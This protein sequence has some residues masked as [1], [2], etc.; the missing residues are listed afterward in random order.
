M[1]AAARLIV[2]R[3]PDEGREFDVSS[4]LAHIGRDGS[5]QI[6]LTDPGLAR[7]QASIVCRGG[8]YALFT[9]LDGGVE[10]DGAQVPAERWVWLPAAADIRFGLETVLHFETSTPQNGHAPADSGLMVSNDAPTDESAAVTPSQKKDG[11]SSTARRRRKKGEP[12]KSAARLTLDAAGEPRVQLGADGRLPELNLSE[13]GGPV[14]ESSGKSS[15]QPWLVIVAVL[16]STAMSALLLLWTPESGGSSTAAHA[17]A[18]FQL[19][20]FYGKEGSDLEPYQQLLRQAAVEH[21]QGRIREERRMYLKVLD[22][23]NSAD[24][25]D[26]GNFHGLTGRQTG[27]GRNSDTEL[28]ELLESLVSSP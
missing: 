12:K 28:R 23:L 19:R 27:R 16:A 15:V 13:T 17:Q 3:G 8:R 6:V 7:H 25:L 26:T 1:N 5:N 14:V 22:R 24:V 21:S 20:N 18:R 2:T 4:D 9:P 10:V 11:S